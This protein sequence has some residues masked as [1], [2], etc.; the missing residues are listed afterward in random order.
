M[1]MFETYRPIIKAGINI[2]H[3]ISM[4]RYIYMHMYMYVCMYM[5]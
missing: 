1:H 3:I 5:Y 2:L 4:S